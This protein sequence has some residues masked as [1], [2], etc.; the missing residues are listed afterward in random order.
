MTRIASGKPTRSAVSDRLARPG[1]RWTSATQRPGERTELGADDHRADDQDDRV[2]DDPDRGDH[3]REHHEREKAA[4]ENGALERARL[5]LLPDDRV[6]RGTRSR[7]LGLLGAPRDGRVDLDRDDAA[8]LLEPEL[9][10]PLDQRA[11]VLARDVG[12]HDVPDGVAGHAGEV[13]DAV[14]RP[15]R[16]QE[17]QH[18]VAQVRRD[19][20]TQMDHG[21]SLT[22]T[23]D[24][25]WKSTT[26]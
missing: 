10:Q 20:E 11:R 3:G 23:P 16:V 25:P 8:A 24:L 12:E 15:E 4:G 5:D 17:S 26:F 9:A 1:R 2:G 21:R 6:G 7:A 14:G 22:G 18:P 19:D 13:D